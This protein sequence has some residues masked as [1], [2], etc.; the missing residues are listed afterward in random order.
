[1]PMDKYS[2]LNYGMRC[3]PIA[4]R[5]YEMVRLTNSGDTP[6]K[7]LI[8]SGVLVF[9]PQIKVGKNTF[10]TTLDFKQALIT[11]SLTNSRNSTCLIEGIKV[12]AWCALCQQSV[13]Q[14]GD[15]IQSQ[16]FD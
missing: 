1:M 4:L 13:C 15:N 12:Q 14:F 10:R 3:D 8:M 11:E 7:P 9:L 5:G 16:C 2:S 6:C